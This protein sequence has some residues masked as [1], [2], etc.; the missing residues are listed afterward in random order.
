MPKTPFRGL[1][2]L[3]VL[4]VGAGQF[5]A[6]A[7]Q[8]RLRLDNGASLNG[9]GLNGTSFNGASGHGAAT[10]ASPAD[11]GRLRLRAVRLAGDDGR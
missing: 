3:A 8:A 6:P 1:A 10:T 9:V 5:L 11:A 7:A 2:A 4:A